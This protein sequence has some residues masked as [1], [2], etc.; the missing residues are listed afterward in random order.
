MTME[1]KE[2]RCGDGI[3][4]RLFREGVVQEILRPW[5]P[6]MS[7]AQPHALF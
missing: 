6:T 7:T 4:A 3:A 1:E 2:G 5:L